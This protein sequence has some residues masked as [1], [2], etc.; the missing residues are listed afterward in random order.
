MKKWTLTLSDACACGNP[1]TMDHIMSCSYAPQCTA[2]DLAG[3]NS[4][5]LAC[6]NHWKDGIM[7]MAR[8]DEEE[9]KV[10]QLK[11]FVNSSEDDL[12]ILDIFKAD[13]IQYN[14]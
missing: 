5:A 9:E 2:A 4:A 13:I 8:H 7:K 6:A 10:Y 14:K 3:P 11:Q 1:Q 12:L